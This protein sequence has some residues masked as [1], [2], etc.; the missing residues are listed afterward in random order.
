MCDDVT[1]D[2]RGADPPGWRASLWE[3]VLDEVLSGLLHDLNGRV[4]GLHGAHMLI[5]A[6]GGD[7][8]LGSLME[9]ELHA[10]Q[11]IVPL[12]RS[13]PRSPGKAETFRVRSLVEPMARLAARRRRSRDTPIEIHESDPAPILHGDWKGW[14]RLV[15]T[16]L[17]LACRAA[18]RSAEPVIVDCD[19]LEEGNVRLAV[20][21]GGAAS[22][23]PAEDSA[24][25]LPASPGYAGSA[26]ERLAEVRGMA[27]AMGGRLQAEAAVESDGLRLAVTC[28]SGVG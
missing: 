25:P 5:R 1:E 17:T 10:L 8:A 14:G 23:S 12:L 4:A 3:D 7:E 21:T 9:G 2:A 27:A 24:D 6:E 20:R 26:L 18:Q 19:T 16:M 11:E 13:L 15:L 28:P 22:W